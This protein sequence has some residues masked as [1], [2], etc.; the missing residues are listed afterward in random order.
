[1]PFPIK[2]SPSILSAEYG[3]LAEAVREA[4]KAGGHAIHVD[5]MDGHYCHNFAFGIDVVPALKKYVG[6]PIVAHLE[7]DNPDVFIEDFA[8]AGC[9]MI[10]VQEDVCPHLPRTIDRILESGVKAGVG[11]SPDR[12]FEKLRVNPEILGKIDLF[13]V[14]SVYPG[15]GGQPFSP[16]TFSKLETARSLREEQGAAFDIGVDGSVNRE[17]TPGI[18]RAG[19]NYLIAGSSVFKGDIAK[20][21]EDLRT[22]GEGALDERN[23]GAKPQTTT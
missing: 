17:T 2:V 11:L 15:F 5:I 14:L 6:I 10:V 1:M 4:E 3:Y 22:L 20:N 23:P 12:G 13:I 19:C 21:I 16:V 9:D 7:I 18:V 8:R